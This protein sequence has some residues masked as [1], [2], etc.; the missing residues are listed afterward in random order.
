MLSVLLHRLRNAVGSV[1]NKVIVDV[2]RQD[3][4]ILLGNSWMILSKN[5][6]DVGWFGKVHRHIGVE[7]Q[8]DI[9][10]WKL[11]LLAGQRTG[12]IAGKW[13]FLGAPGPYSLRMHS[14]VIGKNEM[15]S[16]KAYGFIHKPNAEGLYWGEWNS[17]YGETDAKEHLWKHLGDSHEV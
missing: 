13:I 8:K 3:A 16:Q 10:T 2:S 9:P 1:S 15:T 17:E 14:A 12:K 11:A 7:L 4:F 6:L 5:S